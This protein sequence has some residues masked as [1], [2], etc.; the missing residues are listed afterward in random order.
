VTDT[1]IILGSSELGLPGGREAGFALL[2]AYASL[3]GAVIDTAAM[4]SD[5]VP[6][7]T[8]RSE[9][10]IGEWMAARG[11]RDRVKIT[12]KGAHPPFDNMSVSRCDPAS[13]RYDVEHSLKRLRTD[14]ID[15]YYLHR[16]DPTRP[17]AE[18]VG[19]L[20]DLHG[21]GKILAF[22]GSN[23]SVARIDEAL[24][25]PG[26]SFRATQV[27]GNA[28]CVLKDPPVD[29]TIVTLDA[30][31]F[32]QA[33]RADLTLDLFSSQAQGLFEKRQAGAPIRPSYDNKAC[34]GAAEKIEAIAARE[35]IEANELTLAYLLALAPNVR[36]VIGPRNP[37]QLRQSWAAGDISLTPELVRE[38]AAVTEQSD[39][40]D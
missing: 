26:E 18:I 22:G 35:Q 10:I 28:L 30:D 7:E 27:L 3:G 14:R 15:L 25:L 40:L 6:G 19:T 17:V 9:N 38:I 37:E 29:K 21:E 31:A 5:W 12:T 11:N 32:R 13:I 8:G 34:L 23:W 1:R 2:D 4:Y 24:R 20:Q 36:A 16:D 39:F 33:I